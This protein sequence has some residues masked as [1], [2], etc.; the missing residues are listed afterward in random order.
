M[1][2]YTS[3]AFLQNASLRG[4]PLPLSDYLYNC[5]SELLTI[6]LEMMGY[7]ILVNLFS[8]FL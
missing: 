4:E 5:Y 6:L 7:V 8:V 1:L 3:S 2:A